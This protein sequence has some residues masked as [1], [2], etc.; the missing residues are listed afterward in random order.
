MNCKEDSML[1]DFLTANRQ[2]LL[3]RCKEKVS[4]RS[5]PVANRAESAHGIPCFLDQLTNALRLDESLNTTTSLKVSGT[6]YGGPASSASE[7]GVMAAKH[8]NELLEQGFTIGQVVHDYGDLCQAVTELAAEKGASINVKE[9]RTLNCCLDAAIAAAVT[10]YS[11]SRDVVVSDQERQTMNERW[12][13]LAHEMRNLLHGV[14]LTVEVLKKGS[15]GLSDATAAV[16]DRN[17][18]AMRDLVNRSFAQVHLDAGLP[19]A[20]G[21]HLSPSGSEQPIAPA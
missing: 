12:G 16:L 8:G 19:I 9:F 11:G 10:A 15:A 14:V 3:D 5:A 17:L 7:I 6:P 13:A 20:K 1:H 2:E 21:R 4:R 18:S